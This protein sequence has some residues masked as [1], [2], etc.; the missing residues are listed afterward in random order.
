[1]RIGDRY[2]PLG[3]GVLHVFTG[4]KEHTIETSDRTVS[5]DLATIRINGLPLPKDSVVWFER[6]NEV[7]H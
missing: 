2:H 6:V 1:M 5:L 7:W 3:A 4:E